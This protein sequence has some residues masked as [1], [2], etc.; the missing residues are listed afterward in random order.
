LSA[1][2]TADSTATI[3]I[4]GPVEASD[5][6]DSDHESQPTARASPVLHVTAEEDVTDIADLPKARTP[7]SV[8]TPSRTD[9]RV[10]AGS[11]PATFARDVQTAG[12]QSPDSRQTGV[13]PASAS[14]VVADAPS[15]SRAGSGAARYSH[16]ENYQSLSGRLE[17]SHSTQRWKLRY[18]PIDGQTDQYGGSVVLNGAELLKGYKAGDFVTIQGAVSAKAADGR[19]FSPLYELRRVE[20]QR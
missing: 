10:A 6:D 13:V 18:I 15:G 7:D 2:Q 3:R 20:P 11:R 8:N 4:V 14:T 16:G 12:W 19:A 9:N 1:G 17:Y 5:G